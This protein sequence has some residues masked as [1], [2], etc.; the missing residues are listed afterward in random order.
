[1]KTK[2]KLL[3]HVQYGR[4]RLYPGCPLSHAI[5]AIAKGKVFSPTEAAILSGM[6]QCQVEIKEVATRPE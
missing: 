4:E 1:M 6:G 3:K 5:I 2:I